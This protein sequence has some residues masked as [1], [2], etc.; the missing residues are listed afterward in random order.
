MGNE[1]V[2]PVVMILKT[3]FYSPFHSFIFLYIHVYPQSLCQEL[4]NFFGS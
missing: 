4:K 1:K 3:I 2:F